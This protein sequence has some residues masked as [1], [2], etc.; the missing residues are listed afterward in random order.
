MPI[1]DI[2]LIAAT[3]RQSPRL[4]GA[5][6]HQVH[7]RSIV[8]MHPLCLVVSVVSVL[9]LPVLLALVRRRPIYQRGAVRVNTSNTRL[10]SNMGMPVAE[11]RVRSPS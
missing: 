6:L 3:H 4:L 7:R 1:R 5:S 9:L 10:D 2:H 8:G 11:L